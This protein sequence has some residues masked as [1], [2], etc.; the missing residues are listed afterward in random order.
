MCQ[1]LLPLRAFAPA[2]PCYPDHPMT[3]FQTDIS[4]QS[5]LLP[6]HLWSYEFPSFSTLCSASFFFIDPPCEIIL[7]VYKC[8]LF[9]AS[10]SKLTSMRAGILSILFITVS[11]VPETV[12]SSIILLNRWAQVW[13]WLQGFG[14][15]AWRLV[16]PPTPPHAIL[17][18]PDCE[19]VSN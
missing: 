7:Y 1:A 17:S 14:G 15:R 3:C 2:I 13:T 18:Q 16:Y 4:F 12:N 5:S 11:S 19:N 9:V 10:L 8:H 6:P